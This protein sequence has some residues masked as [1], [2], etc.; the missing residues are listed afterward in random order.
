MFQLLV[1]TLEISLSKKM[2]KMYCEENHTFALIKK[3]LEKHTLF[4]LSG[5]D[6]DS[7][8]THAFVSSRADFPVA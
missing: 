6:P 4:P 3:Q 5:L 2:R 7:A 1:N 8:W